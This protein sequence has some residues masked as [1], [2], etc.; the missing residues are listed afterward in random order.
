MKKFKVL[1]GMLLAAIVA[2]GA[3]GVGTLSVFAQQT[4]P[5]EST[6]AEISLDDDLAQRNALFLF[7]NCQFS[8]E[9]KR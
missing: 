1:A 8:K 4:A 6:R 5:E 7:F 9:V 3:A 2:S